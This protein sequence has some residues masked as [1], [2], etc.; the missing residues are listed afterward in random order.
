MILK[1]IKST[2]FMINFASGCSH[3]ICPSGRGT[4]GAKIVN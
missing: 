3:R 1:K 4:T 2:F